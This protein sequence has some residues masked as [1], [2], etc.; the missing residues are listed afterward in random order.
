MTMYLLFFVI[1]VML[2]V[3]FKSLVYPILYQGRKI[4]MDKIT[5]VIKIFSVSVISRETAIQ[6]ITSGRMKTLYTHVIIGITPH[7]EIYTANAENFEILVNC[8][9]T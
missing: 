1:V 8:V 2:H 5:Q 9:G 4:Q 7:S 3:Q 6:I